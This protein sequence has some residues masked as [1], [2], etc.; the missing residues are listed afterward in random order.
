MS[1]KRKSPVGVKIIACLLLLG[2]LAAFLLPWMKLTADVGR[3]QTR[4]S[5][6]ELIQNFAG[7]DAAAVL[8]Q[9]EQELEASGFRG[10]TGALADLLH[11]VLNGRFLPH[12]LGILCRDV[13]DVCRMAQ[14]HDL[15]GTMETLSYAVWGLFGLLALLGIIA[16]I[17]QLS[18]HRGGIVPYFLLGALIAGGLLYLRQTANAYLLRESQELLAGFGLAG[19][20][21]VL[22]IDVQIVKMGI[23][24]YLC[25]F[26]A[27]LALLLMGIKKKEQAPH[28]QASPYPARRPAAAAAAAGVTRPAPKPTQSAGQKPAGS[29]AARTASTAAPARSETPKPAADPIREGRTPLPG[30]TSWTCSYCGRRMEADKN[31]CDLCGSPKPRR[32][33]A[34]YCPAC[35]SRLGPEAR[36]CSNCG[37][38]VAQTPK[39]ADTA[40]GG[41][42]KQA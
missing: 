42:E 6:G 30:E 2:S 31:F 25:P 21:S 39:S 34:A 37:S 36:F 33:A 40:E 16:L 3:D 24:A 15:A 7:M 4:M 23:G 32:R 41:T 14:R 20:D 17:C 38:R 28:Y 27:L 22:G 12:E 9:V 10:D 11:R 35:G 29:G 19:I 5:L 13:G 1:T 8:D 18:D 26:L